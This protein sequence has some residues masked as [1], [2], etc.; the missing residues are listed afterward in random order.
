MG[1]PRAMFCLPVSG[2]GFAKAVP[3]ANVCAQG[4]GLGRQAACGYGRSCRSTIV[5]STPYQPFQ[6][7]IF[8]FL[9][10]DLLTGAANREVEVVCGNIATLGGII[11]CNDGDFEDFLLDGGA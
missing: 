7:P 8:K 1:L 2:V 11:G 9:W 3:P 10:V 6:K 5:C 4:F